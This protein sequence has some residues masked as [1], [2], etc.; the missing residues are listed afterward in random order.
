MRSKSSDGFTLI[1]IILVIFL[2]SILFATSTPKFK[3][4]GIAS[5]LTQTKRDHLYLESGLQAYFSDW[6]GYPRQNDPNDP[7]QQG[8]KSLTFPIAY[9][10][11][12]PKDP[13]SDSTVYGNPLSDLTEYEAGSGCPPG[14]ASIEFGWPNVN[15]GTCIHSYLLMGLGPNQSDD[16]LGNDFWPH[17]GNSANPQVRLFSYSPTNGSESRGDIYRMMGAFAQGYF[18]LDDEII[19]QPQTKMVVKEDE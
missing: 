19:G 16:T 9:L 7:S 12:V 2:V 3:N 11:E 10:A 6:R 17:G 15:N 4:A 5:K 8:L 13:F 1:E 18:Q 14:L